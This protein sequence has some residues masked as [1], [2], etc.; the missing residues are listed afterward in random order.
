MIFSDLDLARRVESVD[1]HA[2]PEYARA[3]AA[4]RPESGA[5]AIRVAG[6]AAVYAGVGSPVTQAMGLGL[7]G[8]VAEGQLDELEEFFRSR[9]A[10]TEIEVCPLADASLL[11]LLGRRGYRVLE[12]SNVLVRS[13]DAA[14]VGSPPASAVQVRRAGPEDAG[15]W[16]GIMTRCFLE[17]EEITQQARDLIEPSL[18]VPS[19]EGLLGSLDGVVAGCAGMVL[20]QGATLLAGAATLPAWRNRG[21]QAALSQA[22]LHLAVS[23]GC[24]LAVTMTR[25]G[26]T[27]QR[28]AERQGFRIIYTRAKMARD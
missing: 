20:H 21:V 10:R 14:G 3:L 27:S 24:D 18:H 26:S 8:P 19:F 7:D 17:Q 12:W 4:L 22:R 11:E 25:P 1:A 23:A 9:G 28:N 13:L 2:G 5:T 6:G 15:V 16:T